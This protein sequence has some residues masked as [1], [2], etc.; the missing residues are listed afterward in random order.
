MHGA[1]RQPANFRHLSYVNPAAP[2][3]GQLALGMLGAYD[4][5]NPFIIKGTAASGLRDYVFESLLTRSGDE[6]FTLY[7]LIAETLEMPADRGSITFH[8]RA[9][10]R[11]ADGQPIT[12]EDVLFSHRVLREKGWPFH[13]SHYGKVA[14]AEK[15]GERG[16]RFTFA[17]A[18]DREVPMLIGL[19]P[20]LPSHKLTSETFERT[21][22]EPP[23]GSGPY[24]VAR[25]DAGR[26]IVY[27]R[28]NDWWA[29]DLPI[30]RGRFNFDEI[31]VEY[32]RD[33]SAMFEA[34]K[35]G[36]LDV[37]V[38]NDPGRWPDGYRFRAVEEGRI[39]L[40]AFDTHLPSGMTSIVFNSRRAHLSDTRVRQALIY[41]FDGEWINRALYNGNYRR[42]QSFFERSYL[43]AHG[44]PA[45]EREQRLLAP[46]TGFVK[47][48]VMDGN[49]RLPDGDGTGD[50]RE[51]LLIAH[52]L[53]EE[54][55]YKF[56]NGRLMKRGSRLTLEFLAQTRAQERLMLS[57]GRT[58]A[59]LGI[60]LKVRHVDSAQYNARL[61]SF[62][63]DMVVWTW[64]ASLSPGNEQ[65]NRWGSAAADSDGSL[66]LTGTKNAAADAMIE[67]LLRADGEE[68][69]VSAVRALDRVLISGDYVIPLFYLPQVWV[70]HGSHLRFP[71][72]APLSGYDL[73]A[74]WT[75]RR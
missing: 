38:E 18:G 48:D 4:S 57:Y 35:A 59:R 24:V 5:L 19:M 28:N 50:N 20:I 36:E 42:T 73:D 44:K 45:D 12:P 21:T 70:A 63:F 26:S 11:F 15:I 53:L 29:R 74:W 75:E 32:F 33:A 43:S 68:E 55:G 46:F 54:A 61:R 6:P 10:A 52:G 27:R 3:G 25:V 2:K 56:K 22:L 7:G 49:Y 69:F 47:P 14:S 16:V 1:P 51:N 34:F 31:R 72:R 39:L 64:G 41:A 58:L 13:R 40:Q 67:A 60:D 37:R 65:S 62:D 8:L 17:E 71:P 30:N 9:E 66:N 23:L